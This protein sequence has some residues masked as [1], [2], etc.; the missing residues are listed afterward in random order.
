MLHSNTS[1]AY[2][3]IFVSLRMVLVGWLI[4][5]FVGW[6]VSVGLGLL[7]FFVCLVWFGLGFF[8]FTEEFQIKN[9]TCSSSERKF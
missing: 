9:N 8:S 5:W 1:V 4:V 7:G 6:L 3:R 2:N